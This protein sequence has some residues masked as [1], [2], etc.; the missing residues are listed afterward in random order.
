LT[1]PE[2]PRSLYLV[3]S[4]GAGQLQPKVIKRIIELDQPQEGSESLSLPPIDD[5]SSSS[6]PTKRK[7]NRRGGKTDEEDEKDLMSVNST[8]TYFEIVYVD[9][10]GNEVMMNEDDKNG[11]L[12]V[13]TNLG[14]VITYPIGLSI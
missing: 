14:R 3:E 9:P 8:E 5:S 4:P 12:Y 11:T 13:G 10:D 2:H 7:N 1:F 6:S